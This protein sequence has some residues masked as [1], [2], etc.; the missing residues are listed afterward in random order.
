MLVGSV[1]S[2]RCTCAWFLGPRWL[3]MGRV[4]PTQNTFTQFSVAAAMSPSHPP[5]AGPFFGA[6]A[7]LVQV[8]LSGHVTSN[9][10]S[11]THTGLSY[12]SGPGD[13]APIRTSNA[14]GLDAR[15][16]CQPYAMRMV[17]NRNEPGLIIFTTTIARDVAKHTLLTW[18]SSS[19]SRPVQC[20]D[21]FGTDDP[22]PPYHRFTRPFRASLKKWEGRS[23]SMA[24]R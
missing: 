23:T 9:V 15:M 13:R 19:F 10:W 11:G 16:A 18:R 6:V 12:V 2:T 20:A 17:T 3:N 5:S 4:A 14:K 1:M 21:A 8:L 24:L 22:K 7:P